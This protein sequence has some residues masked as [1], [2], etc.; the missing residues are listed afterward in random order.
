MPDGMSGASAPQGA[1]ALL[2][3]YDRIVIATSGGVDSMAMTLMALE[4]GADPSTIELHHHE[5]DGR[6]GHYMDW[7]VTT[8]YV[9][10]IAAHLGLPLHLSWRDGGMRAEMNKLDETSGPVCYETP[11]GAVRRLVNPRAP[12]NTR[13]LFPQKSNDHRVRWCSGFCKIDCLRQLITNED[14][15]LHARTIVLTGERAEES[16]ARSRYAAF[17]TF[18]SDRRSSPRLG[19]HVDHWRPIL[20]WSKRDAWATMERWSIMPHPAYWLGW[21]RLSCMC[22]VFASSNQW[23]T[24]RVLFPAMFAAILDKEM[25]CGKTITQGMSVAD[26]ADKGK[27][28]PSARLYPEMVAAAASETWNLPIQ[29]KPWILPP[30]AFGEMAGPS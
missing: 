7:P 25:S 10:A 27:P 14:R 30:G 5:V 11:S 15:F 9:R 2:R 24:I 29:P 21:G 18:H 6:A 17:E 8:S 13:L 19:R 16:P 26:M 4:A 1:E 28:Y 12:T 22:C 23:A 20:D 3:S